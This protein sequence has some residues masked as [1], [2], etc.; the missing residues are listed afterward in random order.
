MTSSAADKTYTLS[1]FDYELPSELIAR[2]PLPDRDASRM[3]VLDRAAGAFSHQAFADL[4]GLISPGDLLV[5]N[6]AKVMPSRLHGTREGHQGKV[7]LF[8]MH[9]ENSD[10]TL[11]HVLMRP[12]RRL[13]PGT[14]VVFSD[15]RVKAEIVEQREE[16]RGL[17]QLTWDGSLSFDEALDAVGSIPIPPYLQR[18][19]EKI[20]EERYQTV[21]AKVPGAQA[22]P[23]AG[24]HFTPHVLNQLQSKGVRILEVTLH[25]SAGTFRPVLSETVAEHRMDPEYYTIPEAVAE[26]ISDTRQQGNRV[27]AVGTTVAKTL[28]TS[29]F[30]NQGQVVAESRWS[31][32]FITPGFSFQA[33]DALLTNFHLPKSTLMMLVSAFANRELIMQAYQAAVAEKYRF[34]SYGDCM[35]IQ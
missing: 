27:I 10:R 2:Y 1:D 9:P 18:D 30:Y 16:G 35:L 29:A 15:L 11:W 13:K 7:E 5:L 12:A 31:E 25:V 20:D 34:Y 19:P 33:V 21:F 3:L 22:A 17:V 6:N 14:V 32:L 28:E 4:P 8:L 24:L 23:T 26:A